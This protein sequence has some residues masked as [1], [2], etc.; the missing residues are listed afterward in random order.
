[1]HVCFY[2]YLM[3]KFNAIFILLILIIPFIDCESLYQL[4]SKSFRPKLY[5][6]SP[7]LESIISLRSPGSFYLVIQ[8]HIL[9]VRVIVVIGVVIVVTGVVFSMKR[10]NF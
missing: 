5:L 10:N 7:A 9:L 3:F 4:A 8:N 1:M 6:T 2:V